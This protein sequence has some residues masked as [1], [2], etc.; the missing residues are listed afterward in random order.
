MNIIKNH[1]KG[2]FTIVPNKIIEDESIPDRARFLFIF[3]IH[4][5]EDWIFRTNKICECL[6]MHADT[7]RKYRNI[8]SEKGWI[9]VEKQA[10][11]A[12]KFRSRIYHLYP[13]PTF[14]KKKQEDFENEKNRISPSRE[15]TVTKKNSGGKNHRLNN[16]EIKQKGN[17]TKNNFNNKENTNNSAMQNPNPRQK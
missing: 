6:G 3:L 14:N 17:Q 16:K 1:F 4:K 8:L 13:E 10:F 5:P 9:K 7:F 11:S 12:G 2:N 15:K